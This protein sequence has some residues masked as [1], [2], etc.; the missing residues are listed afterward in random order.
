[1][2]VT[3]GIRD[4][5]SGVS[6]RWFK[7]NDGG[8]V[9]ASATLPIDP[10]TGFID[11]LRSYPELVSWLPVAGEYASIL[12]TGA[13]INLNDGNA[14]YNPDGSCRSI[15]ISIIGSSTR[16]A[17][18]TFITRVF[19]RSVGVRWRRAG[20][21][22]P[23]IFD[24]VID[25]VAYRCYEGVS[26]GSEAT[27]NG[28]FVVR[29]LDER[30]HDVSLVIPDSGVTSTNYFFMLFGF[31]A[32]GIGWQKRLRGATVSAPAAVPF[33]PAAAGAISYQTASAVWPMSAVRKIIYYNTTGADITVTIYRDTTAMTAVLVPAN[34]SAELDFGEPVVFDNVAPFK[35]LA[36]ATGVISTTIGRV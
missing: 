12:N 15:G 27:Y 29:D 26:Y 31:L 20:S 18:A 33:T 23:P 14:V 17:G 9:P 7:F 24:L 34:K 6:P 10:D 8:R 35:H 13:S 2:F 22:P 28:E 30:N 32:E 21:S 1:M 36:S 25:G 19:G 4:L 16:A 3:Q 5:L 11:R